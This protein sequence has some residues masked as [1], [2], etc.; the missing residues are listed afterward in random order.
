MWNPAIYYK[1][2]IRKENDILTMLPPI[3]PH[4]ALD[5]STGED[6][7]HIIPLKTTKNGVLSIH[8]LFYAST[9][10]PSSGPSPTKHIVEAWLEDK[11]VCTSED[12][13]LVDLKAKPATKE[14]AEE[15]EEKEKNP[16]R[17]DVNKRYRVI[18][19]GL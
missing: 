5:E 6:H 14:D 9:I 7:G 8:D 2:G 1:P 10:H 4:A 16:R 19:V 11:V 3:L 15:C 17:R 18:R 13:W 12:G